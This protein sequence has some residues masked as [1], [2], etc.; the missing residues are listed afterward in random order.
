[1]Q[2]R[3]TDGLAAAAREIPFLSHGRLQRV[4]GSFRQATGFNSPS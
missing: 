2:N 3:K 4:E 1:M